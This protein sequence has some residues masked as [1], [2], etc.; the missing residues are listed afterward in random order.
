MLLRLQRVGHDLVTKQQHYYH[1]RNVLEMT[2]TQKFNRLNSPSD[3]ARL[4]VQ[5]QWKKSHFLRAEHVINSCLISLIVSP[6][7]R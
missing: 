2:R 3:K 7:K 6:S 5:I 1:C 4:Q